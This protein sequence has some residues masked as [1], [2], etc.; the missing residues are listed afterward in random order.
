MPLR[1]RVPA[2]VAPAWLTYLPHIV[3]VAPAQSASRWRVWTDCSRRRASPPGCARRR[4]RRYRPSHQLLGHRRR[5][6]RSRAAGG[7]RACCPRRRSRRG[8][9]SPPPRGPPRRARG[10]LGAGRAARAEGRGRPAARGGARMNSIVS[11]SRACWLLAARLHHPRQP[12]ASRPS[13]RES[14]EGPA[15]ST[16]RRATGFL[17]SRT[18]S[19]TPA[20]AHARGQCCMQARASSR[21]D[22]S[23]SPLQP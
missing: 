17:L 9:A 12:R 16:R 4:L 6:G 15:D 23:L 22:I 10:G 3:W 2:V 19:L 21:D 7:L 1:P 5:S 8:C 14:A 13:T 11:G 20:C 18:L